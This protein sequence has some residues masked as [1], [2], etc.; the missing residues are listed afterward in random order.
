MFMVLGIITIR[1]TSSIYELGPELAFHTLSE[2]DF[3]EIKPITNTLKIS[4]Y[5]HINSNKVMELDLSEYWASDDCASECVQLEQITGSLIEYCNRLLLADQDDYQDRGGSTSEME[6]AVSCVSTGDEGGHHIGHGKDGAAAACLQQGVQVETVRNSNSCAPA[7]IAARSTRRASTSSKNPVDISA[8][9]VAQSALNDGHLACC[10]ALRQALLAQNEEKVRVALEA[11]ISKI[12]EEPW[13]YLKLHLLG[14]LKSTSKGY[15]TVR[16]HSRRIEQLLSLGRD[17][18]KRRTFAAQCGLTEGHVALSGPR[19]SVASIPEKLDQEKSVGCS[20]QHAK[21]ILP[22]SSVDRPSRRC[23]EAEE[24]NDNEGCA[25]RSDADHTSTEEMCATG[26]IVKEIS[27]RGL[28]LADGT[29]NHETNC[30]KTQIAS[31]P[32]YPHNNR[33]NGDD[34]VLQTAMRMCLRKG[35][36]YSANAEERRLFGQSLQLVERYETRRMYPLFEEGTRHLPYARA[37][38]QQKLFL[39][40]WLSLS[41]FFCPSHVAKYVWRRVLLKLA[42]RVRCHHRQLTRFHGFVA[43][44]APL[45]ESAIVAGT[46]SVRVLRARGCPWWRESLTPMFLIMSKYTALKQTGETTSCLFCM[47]ISKVAA[48]SLAVLNG[49]GGGNNYYNPFVLSNISSGASWAPTPAS[50]IRDYLAAALATTA[51]RVKGR[52]TQRR[53]E[54]VTTDHSMPPG[55]LAI[56]LRD[57]KGFIFGPACFRDYNRI[58]LQNLAQHCVTL[59]YKRPAMLASP[60]NHGE[61]AAV[62]QQQQPG[63]HLLTLCFDEWETLFQWVTGL[64]M[65]VKLRGYASNCV[66]IPPGRLLWRRVLFSLRGKLN[67]PHFS[68][69]KCINGMWSQVKLDPGYRPT[70]LPSY[71]SSYTSFAS[72]G[73]G[74]SLTRDRLLL[75]GRAFLYSNR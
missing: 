62:Q 24:E 70:L 1:I 13:T 43:D 32:I 25:A 2:I 44:Q 28:L 15:S 61:T 64:G 60:P 5:F 40:S 16:V 9:E 52:A 34:L 22:D 41:S 23:P 26:S 51:G 11:L 72:I 53:H 73:M 75:P 31:Q 74:G 12:G 35:L 59:V 8:Q 30:A 45:I 69:A 49:G 3:V 67:R 58:I 65:Q 39:A 6:E 33:N 18:T 66:T 7:V 20:I 4:R 48:K 63:H 17:R 36:E 46:A 38:V 50:M 57:I 14:N 21:R 29:R 56:D 42:A 37:L 68:F 10:A 19:R 27:D 47:P 55:A 54:N 71:N